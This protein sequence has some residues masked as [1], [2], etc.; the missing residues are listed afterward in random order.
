MKR[1]Y[2]AQSGGLYRGRKR[3][4]F[5]QADRDRSQARPA[6]ARAAAEIALHPRHHRADRRQIDLVVAGVQDLIVRPEWGMTV[7]AYRGPGDDKLVRFRRERA[8][9]AVASDAALPRAAPLLP[10]RAVRFRP[11][12]GRQVGVVRCLRRLPQPRLQF[13]DARGQRLDLSPE[14]QDQ[15]VLLSL[16][17]LV[18]IG[19]RNHPIVES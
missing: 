14:R 4:S 8:T 7:G 12:G 2:R 1:R 3:R 5:F 18:Q 19:R 17:Q 13:R 16:T 11:F 10:L 6:A 15:R 9:A